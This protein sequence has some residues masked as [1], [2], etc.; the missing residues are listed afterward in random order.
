MIDLQ[1][2]S[3]PHYRKEIADYQDFYFEKA[4]DALNNWKS[5]SIDVR[6]LS[7]LLSIPATEC[8]KRIDSEDALKSI[9]DAIYKLVSYCDINASD[10]NFYNDYEDKRAFAKAGIRQHAWIYQWL[11]Y[12]QNPM[13]VTESIQN[14]LDYL[15][16]PE[17]NFPIVSEDHKVQLSKNILCKPYNRQ[18]FSSDLLV[19]YDSLGFACVNPANKTYLYARMFYSYK[20]EWNDIYK[21]KGLVVRDST[22]WKEDYRNGTEKQGYSVMWRH[23]LPSNGESVLTSLKGIIDDGNSFPFYIVENN[24]TTYKATVIDFCKRENYPD[25]VQEWEKKN[26]YGFAND[27]SEYYDGN[28]SAKIV[29]LDNNFELI[30]PDE[31]F[32]VNENF[33]F[34]GSTK[35][36]R[37][38]YVAFTDIITTAEIKMNQK[39]IDIANLL[40]KKKNIILQGAPGTGKTYTTASIALKVLG[41]ANVDWNDHKA[42]M[43]EYDRLI[44]DG[45]IAFT[46][47][48]QSMD[49][50]DF[51]EGYK[52][53]SNGSDMKFELKKGVFRTIC[54]KAKTETC[55]LIIDE[56]NRGNISKIFGELITLLEADKRD[57]GNHNIKVNLTYS[58][59]PFSVPSKLYI[60]GTMNTTDRSVGSIDYAL[61]RRFAFYTLKSDRSVV[62]SKYR[63]SE[64]KGKATTLFDE[65]ESFLTKNPADMKIDDL[66]PGHSYFMADNIED[67]KDKLEYELIPLIEEYTKDGIIEVSDDKLNKEFEEWRQI[68]K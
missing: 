42:I 2:I 67:L 33:K 31:R 19:A 30:S 49:Y 41:V 16:K 65:V 12:K 63:D 7:E 62:E 21:V 26:P 22:N 32:N 5:T 24:I 58:Q 64:L 29:F 27:F 61:R 55:V 13:S 47:F 28:Q 6:L 48:H 50:E 40:L 54:E 10:K 8:K 35:P 46:T 17:T 4:Q 20:D 43:E 36:G 45:R 14:V 44:A 3:Q 34:M 23:N 11:K 56:I 52:P 18:T 1:L 25:V 51:V 68:V 57:G 53:V 60:I 37:T 9:K 39:N 38:N 15:E 59:E 66:M